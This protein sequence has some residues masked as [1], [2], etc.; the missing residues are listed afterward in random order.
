MGLAQEVQ[1]ETVRGIHKQFIPYFVGTIKFIA[2]ERRQHSEITEQ[3]STILR[4]SWANKDV[5]SNYLNTKKTQFHHRREKNHET[6]G[7]LNKKSPQIVGLR[8]PMQPTIISNPVSTLFL[9]INSTCGTRRE[10]VG[11]APMEKQNP[12]HTSQYPSLQ[13]L[14]YRPI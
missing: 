14:L 13:V 2:F 8:P 10:G 4:Q 9:Y 1:F 3:K 12:T 5:D 7:I 6:L 11:V